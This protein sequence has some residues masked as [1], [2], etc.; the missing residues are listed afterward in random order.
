MVYVIA[1]K[2]KGKMGKVLR[3]D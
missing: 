1:G 3:I 2:E